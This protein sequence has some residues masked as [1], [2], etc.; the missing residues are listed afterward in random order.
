MQTR[1][2]KT[3]MISSTPLD[4]PE[5]RKQAIEACQRAG[6]L[7][8]HASPST[9]PR[10]P[11]FDESKFEPMPDVELNPEDEFHEDPAPGSMEKEP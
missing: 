9:A 1:T 3:A 10:L 8:N 2:N 6:I 4:L 5:H 7:P 11:P